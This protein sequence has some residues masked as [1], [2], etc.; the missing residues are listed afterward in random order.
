MSVIDTD[1]ASATYQKV[2]ETIEFDGSWPTAVLLDVD[3]RHAYAVDE[4]SGDISVID[5]DPDSPGCYTVVDEVKLGAR[6]CDIKVSPRERRLYAITDNDTAVSVIDPADGSVAKIAVGG[7]PYRIS[8]DPKGSHLY[9]NLHDSGSVCVI[10]TNLASPTCHRVVGTLDFGDHIGD[11][12]FARN[13]AVACVVHSASD[14]VSIIDTG[15]CRVSRVEVGDYPWDVVVGPNGARA[16]VLGLHDDSVSVVDTAT[17]TVVER[18]KVGRHPCRIA[19]DSSGLQVFTANHDD[20]SVSAIAI[21]S[22]KVSSIPVGP[23]PFD[24]IVGPSGGSAF[25]R[26][27]DGISM[28]LV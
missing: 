22:G 15:A 25:V 13:G 14:A 19:L 16:Y 6:L 17:A 10:D 28:L 18:F 2:L 21:G 3:G 8:L 5:A 27:R 7:W 23:T 11:L 9:A 12:V 24:I 20:N 26:H 1:S 4:E